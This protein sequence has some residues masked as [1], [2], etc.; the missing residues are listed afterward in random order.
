MNTEE[1]PP[2]V[3]F[4]RAWIQIEDGVQKS[5]VTYPVRS[6]MLVAEGGRIRRF[7][8]TYHH[9]R[10]DDADFVA[11]SLAELAAILREH[12]SDSPLHWEMRLEH[13]RKAEAARQAKIDQLARAFAL[14]GAKTYLSRAR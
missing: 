5:K 13:D 8:A 7:A 12:F 3:R 10:I 1:E 4:V 2:D 11:R 9:V 6:V 14:A